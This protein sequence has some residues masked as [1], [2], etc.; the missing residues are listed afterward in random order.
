MFVAN[1]SVSGNVT[2]WRWGIARD[3]TVGEAGL[4]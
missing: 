1:A 3:R 4:S 2:M